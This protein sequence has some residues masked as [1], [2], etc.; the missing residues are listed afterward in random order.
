MIFVMKGVDLTAEL[1]VIKVLSEK[2]AKKFLCS[3]WQEI[4]YT[5]N[6]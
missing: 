4:T 2:R 1:A 6:R 3:G 5:E